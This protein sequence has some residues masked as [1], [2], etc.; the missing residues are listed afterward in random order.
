MTFH[1]T[2]EFTDEAQAQQ[3]ADDLEAYGNVT[4]TE[5]NVEIPAAFVQLKEVAVK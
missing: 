2:V 4:I 3:F 5:D 1:V